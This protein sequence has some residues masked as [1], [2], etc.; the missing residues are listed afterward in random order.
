VIQYGQWDPGYDI[1]I[2]AKKKAYLV[3]RKEKRK[4]VVFYELL[5]LF[6]GCRCFLDIGSSVVAPNPFRSVTFLVGWIPVDDVFFLQNTVQFGPFLYLQSLKFV[7]Y[8]HIVQYY[9][10]IHTY[11]FFTGPVSGSFV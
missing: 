2:G 9:I 4:K 11:T 1:R 7:V 10:P 3:Y 8:V 6:E 5:I